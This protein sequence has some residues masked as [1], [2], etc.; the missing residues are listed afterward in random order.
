LIQLNQWYAQQS[1]QVNMWYAQLN[2]QCAR[3]RGPSQIPGRPPTQNDPGEINEDAI[4]DLQIDDEDK[5]VRIRIP[6]NPQGY[7]QR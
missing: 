2:Q 1:Q 4:Q 6:S 7:R 3:G 5:T